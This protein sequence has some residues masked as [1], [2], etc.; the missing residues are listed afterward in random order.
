MWRQIMARGD[1]LSRQ[2]KIIQRLLS[3]HMGK[4]VAELAEALECHPRTVYRDLEALQAA[5]FPL[6]TERRE[7]KNHWAIIDAAKHHVPLPLNMTELT[8][9]YLSR[10]MLRTLQGRVFQESLDTLFDKV[11]ST[12][13]PAVLQFLE[14]MEASI[15]AAPRPHR[16][17]GDVQDL[18]ESISGA[19]EKKKCL[20]IRYH[21]MSRDEETRRVVAPYK[22]WFFDDAFYMIGFCRVRGDIRVFA[23]D[24]IRSFQ[25]LEEGFEAPEDFDIERRIRQ[26]FGVY[27][28][29]PSTVRIRFTPPAAGYIREKKWHDTQKITEGADGSVIFEARVAGLEAMKHWALSWGAN[30]VVLEPASLRESIEKEAQVIAARHARAERN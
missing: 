10:H 7:G 28:G 18:I 5:G 12:L 25:Q 15:V 3:S 23:L 20:D 19:I 17:H 6:Y 2:W 13:Q 14:R 30:A 8:A 24:R 22:I 16:Q 4:T 11:K 29:E 26:S 27:L 9:L 1:Q 21:V